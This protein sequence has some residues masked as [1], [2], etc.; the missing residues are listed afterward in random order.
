MLSESIFTFYTKI[1]VVD[2]LNPTNYCCRRQDSES[3]W[4]NDDAS[5]SYAWR[6]RRRFHRHLHGYSFSSRSDGTFVCAFL[7]CALSGRSRNVELAFVLVPESR[8]LFNLSTLENRV[9]F[10][11][12]HIKLYI[13]IED[14]VLCVVWKRP[15]SSNVSNIFGVNFI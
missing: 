2:I 5:S 13:L 11:D 8:S 4:A 10:K 15:A 6:R 3:F 1:I 7:G 12:F 14:L 9:V